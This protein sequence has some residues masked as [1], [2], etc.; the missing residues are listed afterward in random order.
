MLRKFGLT[1]CLLLA[2]SWTMA[3]EFYFYGETD[4]NPLE[5]KPGEEM[6]FTVQLLEDGKPV[7]GKTLKWTRRGDDGQTVSG[8]AVSD[9]PLVVKTSMETPGFVH[10]NVTGFDAEKKPLKNGEKNAPSFDGGAG[11]R[12][13]EIQG[14]P[15]PADFDAYWNGQ[16]AKLAEVP[17][18]VEKVEVDCGNPNVRCWDVKVACWGGAPVSG[19]LCIPKD[20]AA[21]SLPASV[22]Y[23]G[24]GFSGANKRPS[25]NSITFDINAHGFLNGQPKEYY[26]NLSKTTLKGYAFHKQE[27]EKPETAYFNGMFLRVIRSLQFVK[28]LPEWNGKDLSVSGGSQGGLQCLAAAGLDTDVTACHAVVPWCCDLS[29]KAKQNRLGGWFP[30][31]TDALGYFDAANHAKR[32]RGKTTITVGLGDYV[33]PPSSEIVLFNNLKCEV[34]LTFFQGKT[35]G[36]NMPNAK[37]YMLKK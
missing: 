33:C 24:Y 6:V 19:Y 21:K 30:E 16:K 36:Y 17:M 13:S 18:T 1:L 9:E 22:S 4:K 7:S 27:N 32:I 20:A 35:H 11:V 28:S 12:L 5:Y 37:S 34:N 15:E 23:H 10:L 25:G 14:W 8:E 29:G 31:W 2:A 3:G 26:D